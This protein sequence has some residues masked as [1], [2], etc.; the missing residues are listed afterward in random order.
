VRFRPVQSDL[1]VVT[2][3]G[4]ER[5]LHVWRTV[6]A[7][8]AIHAVGLAE[9]DLRFEGHVVLRDTP[10]PRKEVGDGTS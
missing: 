5:A 6:Q 3:R 1:W 2:G 8:E 4:P 9:V 7:S 10:R